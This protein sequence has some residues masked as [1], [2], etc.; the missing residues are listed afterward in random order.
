MSNTRIQSFKVLNP[1]PNLIERGLPDCLGIVHENQ[2]G[3][4]EKAKTLQ[5]ENELN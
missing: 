4:F 1:T 5:I 2:S 3:V